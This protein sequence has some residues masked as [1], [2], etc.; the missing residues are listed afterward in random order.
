MKT[1]TRRFLLPVTAA[2]VAL[3][4]LL[5]SPAAA[6][7]PPT[8]TPTATTTDA[9]TQA[10]DDGKGQYA[11][12][13][14]ALMSMY[15]KQ[16]GQ[17]LESYLSANDLMVAAAGNSANG[18][19]VGKLVNGTSA[20]AAGATKL[21]ASTVGDL[22]DSL[23]AAG[24]GLDMRNYASLKDMA[25]DVVA[26]AHTADGKVTLAG[27]QWV[28]QLGSLRSPELKTPTV[29]GATM[30][31]IPAEALPF[32][33][34]LDQS[35]A[36]TVLA[37][38]DLFSQVAT[39]GVGSAEL[40]KVFSSQMLGAWEKSNQSLTSALPNKCTGAMLAVM[41]SGDTSAASQYGPCEPACSTG[42]LYL[43]SQ[44]SR[45]FAPDGK[46]LSPN[47]TDKL[48]NYETLLQAQDWRTRDLLEQN[49]SLVQ[50][51]LSDD[52]TA[53]GALLCGAAS[54]ST[55]DVLS[56]TLP[57]IFGSLRGN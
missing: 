12:L 52:G 18:K 56:K 25:T 36:G 35:I 13:T 7:T 14:G 53:G 11:S 19:P 3:T 30:P 47:E 28:A 43:N 16:S 32:G 24:F 27:A 42:G 23:S 54:T 1:R 45:M 37:A 9:P 57:G 33:L 41:A 44:I 26:K 51:L 21:D 40:S 39:S 46:Q 49:P 34:L 22:D 5:G 55:S 31:G 10:P 38:P 8:P 50:G 48:W 29:G 17:T 6:T 4:C 15:A 2:T 20:D